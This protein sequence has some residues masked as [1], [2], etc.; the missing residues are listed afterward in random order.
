MPSEPRRRRSP[1]LK[2]A[3]VLSV[4]MEPELREVLQRSAAEAGMTLSEEAAQ[5]LQ[6][7]L[8][9]EE[10][11]ARM[12]GRSELRALFRLCG[13]VASDLE[14][15]TGRNCFE[16]PA[17]YLQIEQA[18]RQ[19][20]RQFA[21]PGTTEF[22]KQPAPVVGRGTEILS[23]K[24]AAPGAKARQMGAARAMIALHEIADVVN[25]K[26]ARDIRAGLS[27]LADLLPRWPDSIEA[28][29]ANR[30]GKP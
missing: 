20:L 25:P 9:Q 22:E 13:V 6:G 10:T 28:P 29:D 7:S 16:D 27:R 24:P 30:K 8:D 19:V 2:K 5:R 26:L 4:R 3:S 18:V 1:T 17:T 12:W 14:R 15:I 11:D 21:P 23:G